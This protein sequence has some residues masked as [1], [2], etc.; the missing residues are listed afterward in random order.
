ML[1][2]CIHFKVGSLLFIKASIWK[3]G[4]REMLEKVFFN[5]LVLHDKKKLDK[6]FH[7]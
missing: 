3:V 1:L 5:I 4:L 2:T 6:K 7:K